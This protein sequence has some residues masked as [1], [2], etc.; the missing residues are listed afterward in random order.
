VDGQKAFPLL[1][2]ELNDFLAKNP[3]GTS[4][5]ETLFRKYLTTVR[6]VKNATSDAELQKFEQVVGLFRKY[7]GQYDLDALVVLAQ[8]YQE[9][10]LNQTAKSRVGA[11]GIMQLMP[12][13][14]K[15]LNVGDIRRLEPNIHA[16]TKYLR[17]MINQYYKDEPID[18]LNKALLTFASYNAGPAKVA[19][20]RKEA[21]TRGFDANR[22]F[23]NVEVI[24]SESV[25]Q[26][27][28][29]YVANIY[30]YYIAYKLVSQSLEQKARTK[31]QP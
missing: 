11:I 18:D 1:R 17:F 29:R 25:G 20:L 22:W 31:S 26:E 2:A 14:G 6:Y 16:G 8:G 9:S 30:K 24:A 12:A 13:T 28:V 21:A 4:D 3:P 19:Q 5:R 27:T 7:A 10:R 23:N 15:A